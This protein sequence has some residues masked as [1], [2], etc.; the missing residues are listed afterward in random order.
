MGNKRKSI[1]AYLVYWI[2]II[3]APIAAY[4]LTDSKVLKVIIED[5]IYLFC[6]VA[7]AALLAWLL[8]LK[9]EV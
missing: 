2:G 8:Y 9:T 7:I 1:Y 4:K 5:D 3:V 6:W